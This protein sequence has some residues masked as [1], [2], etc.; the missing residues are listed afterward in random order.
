MDIELENKYS[1]MKSEFRKNF[2]TEI[3]PI[4]QETDKERIKIRDKIIYLY[5]FFSILGLLIV[6]YGFLDDMLSY[7]INPSTLVVLLMIL[8]FFGVFVPKSFQTHKTEI[9]K[10]EM[11]QRIISAIGLYAGGLSWY[12]NEYKDPTILKKVHLTN[13]NKEQEVKIND[14]SQGEF[15]GVELEI[16]NATY[17]ENSKDVFKGTIVVIDI[18]KD[19]KC[20]TILAPYGQINWEKE[21]EHQTFED[22][23]RKKYDIFTDNNEKAKNLITAEFINRLNEIKKISNAENISCA[24]IAERVVIAIQKSSTHSFYGETT[25]LF[26]PLE[27]HKQ[28]FQMF[29]EFLSIVKLIDYFKLNER[30]GM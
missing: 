27:S 19:F 15:E 20:H 6:I 24:F 16:I 25:S 12:P 28:Y 2:A 8:Y 13:P 18:N 17:I 29:D 5:V 1:K 11:R 22:E 14:V 7:G 4:I 10:L 21:L 26:K 23:F 30:I 9:F 3:L